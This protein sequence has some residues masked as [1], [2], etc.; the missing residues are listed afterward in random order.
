MNIQKTLT[1]LLGA[2]L[3]CVLPH[4]GWALLN[5]NEVFTRSLVVAPSV[6]NGQLQATATT[7]LL[8][9]NIPTALSVNMLGNGTGVVVTDASGHNT[10]VLSQ[11]ANG[12]P[13]SIILNTGNDRNVTQSVNVNL[14]LQN[15]AAI[16]S[17]I[18]TTTQGAAMGQHAA[19]RSL[20]F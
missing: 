13:A 12:A 19:I 3:L 7:N 14:T 8:P 10:T 17:F 9:N 4:T 20:G 2:I 1:A 6:G 5:G 18:H 15:M 11:T 16:M